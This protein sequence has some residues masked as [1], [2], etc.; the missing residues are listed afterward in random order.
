[1]TISASLRI[2][3]YIPNNKYGNCFVL[4]GK[5]IIISTIFALEE[6]I[7]YQSGR[8]LAEKNKYVIFKF[9]P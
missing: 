4:A 5:L 6:Y 7:I 9:S 2:S 1:M 8:V 3:L